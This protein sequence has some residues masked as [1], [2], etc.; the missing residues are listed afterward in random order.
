MKL[1]LLHNKIISDTATPR[2]LECVES[3]LI[4]MLEAE[5]GESLECVQMYED[6]LSDGFVKSGYFYYPLTV[7]VSGVPARRFIKWSVSEYRR[8]E[9]KIPYAYTSDVALKFSFADAPEGFSEKLSGRAMYFDGD[10]VKLNIQTTA[11]DK[12]FLSGKYSQTFVD[13]MAKEVTREIERAFGIP[14]LRESTLELFLVF[15]PGT[16]M[17]HVVDGATYRRLLVSAKGCSPRDLWIKWQRRDSAAPLTVSD[18]IDGEEV[19][20]EICE[21]VPQ[22]IREKEYRFLVHS[23]ADKY[24]S[25]MSRKHITEWR[26][27]IKRIIKRGEVDKLDVVTEEPERNREIEDKLKAVLGNTAPEVSEPTAETPEDDYIKSLLRGALGVTEET[28]AQEEE[29]SEIPEIPEA[30]EEPIAEPNEETIEEVAEETEEIEEIEEPVLDSEAEA[31]L[32]S[33]EVTYE[34]PAEEQVVTTPAVDEDDLR[35]R[36]EREIREKLEAEARERAERESEMLRALKA[37]NERLAGLIKETQQT[38]EASINEREEEAKRLRLELEA[39]ERAERAE[40]ERLA[41]MARL[42]L[43]EQQKLA[44]EK[45]KEAALAKAKAEEEAREAEKAKEAELLE[46]RRLEEEKRQRELLEEEERRRKEEERARAAVVYVSKN[47][48]LI[49]RR[50]VDPNVVKR[51]HEIILTTIKYFHK[52]NV[53]MKIKATVP[54]PTTVNLNFVKIPETETELLVNI[55]KVLGKSDLGITKVYLE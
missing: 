32:I 9:S 7:V 27:L 15:A 22:K 55:I 2:F 14:E 30:T 4:P 46:L 28:D 17:E 10:S 23:S 39:K 35:A 44:A 48:R 34:E 26:D 13:R 43:L 49:F 18:H 19:Y 8:F 40:R 54:D 1:D 16:Y 20:F 50:Q 6:F 37:E 53:Y 51:I 36:I 25:A 33:D 45:E 38:H 21:E 52:E 41:E 31:A 5:Y 11:T 12:T 3:T 42:A 29:I 24:Q 47:A